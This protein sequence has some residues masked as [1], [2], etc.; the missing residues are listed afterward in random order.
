MPA[1]DKIDCTLSPGDVHSRTARPWHFKDA[2]SRFT[3][4]A[5]P[6]RRWTA[7]LDT[8]RDCPRSDGL[9]LL[10]PRARLAAWQDELRVD[11]LRRCD[12]RSRGA[13]GLAR[14]R[15]DRMVSRSTTSSRSIPATARDPIFDALAVVTARD[16]RG[17]R[18]RPS[19]LSSLNASLASWSSWRSTVRLRL[20][21][22]ASCTCMGNRRHR[23]QGLRRRSDVPR[24]LR[25]P[26]GPPRTRSTPATNR[27]PAIA[28]SRDVLPASRHGARLRRERHS[29]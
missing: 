27:A 24:P 14:R 12:R 13:R 21:T 5:P 16:A 22:A 9:R 15:P 23:P 19:R 11:P 25:R 2:D 26:R 17:R 1:A 8:E 28:S 3:R 10:R 29:A 4:S 18:Q 20:A 7:A 6:A